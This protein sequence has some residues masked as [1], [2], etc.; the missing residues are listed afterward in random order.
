MTSSRGPRLL[1]VLWR[2]SLLLLTPILEVVITE[3]RPPLL[4]FVHLDATWDWRQSQDW[5]SG[6]HG[7]AGSAD[8]SVG[9]GGGGH[10]HFTTS[11]TKGTSLLLPSEEFAHVT[12][13]RRSSAAVTT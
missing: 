9:G 4:T 13:W 5:P 3:E 6:R 12:C 1:P 7:E 10:L 8:V 11:L 2:R